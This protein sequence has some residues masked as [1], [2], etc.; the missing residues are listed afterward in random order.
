MCEKRKQEN[1][2]EGCAAVENELERILA[3]FTAIGEHSDRVI[4]DVMLNIEEI[5]G[6]LSDGKLLMTRQRNVRNLCTL[7]I[8]I[9]QQ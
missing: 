7:E 1:M 3:K 5:K 6:V 2:V 8:G 4:K 9:R